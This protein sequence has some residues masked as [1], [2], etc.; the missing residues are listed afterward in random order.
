M[1][2]ALIILLL[3]AILVLALA[4]FALAWLLGLLLCGAFILRVWRGAGSI[5]PLRWLAYLRSFR[6]TAAVPPEIAHIQ[7]WMRRVWRL[8]FASVLAA[9]FSGVSLA[10]IAAAH[11]R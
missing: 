6:G 3:K 7:L 4:T 5:D 10:L 9:M 11:G 8:A 1:V 2:S